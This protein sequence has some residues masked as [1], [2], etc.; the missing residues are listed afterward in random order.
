MSRHFPILNIFF[1]HIF[2]ERKSFMLSFLS[3]FRINKSI[4]ARVLFLLKLISSSQRKFRKCVH[5]L[6]QSPHFFNNKHIAYSKNGS[7]GQ[8]SK[9][10][11]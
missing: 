6:L 3:A 10:E 11:K 9:A 5:K 7:Q 2:K 4:H 8:R 1:L